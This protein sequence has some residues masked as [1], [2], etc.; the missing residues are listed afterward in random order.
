MKHIQRKLR[1]KDVAEVYSIGL[2]T[3]W[4][5]AKHGLITPNKVSERV[6]LFD[7]E[8]LNKFFGVENV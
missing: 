6:T 3:V 8:E 5:Y 4:Y 1:A 2:S 7:V